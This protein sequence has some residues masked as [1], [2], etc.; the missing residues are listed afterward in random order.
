MSIPAA[1]LGAR[2][3]VL[4]PLVR[5][6]FRLG[7][8]PRPQSVHEDP[9]A[10]ALA[11]RV[12][13]TADLDA[14]AAWCHRLGAWLSWHRRSSPVS[15]TAE[16]ICDLRPC[17]DVPAASRRQPGRAQALDL[18]PAQGGFVEMTFAEPGVT[19]SGG[20]HLYYWLLR[21]FESQVP[22]QWRGVSCRQVRLGPSSGAGSGACQADSTPC[23]QSPPPMLRTYVRNLSY[24]RSLDSEASFREHAGRHADL[25]QRRGTDFGCAL[26]HEAG[27]LDE[28]L[29]ELE[30]SGPSF[31]F[32]QG[33]GCRP[34]SSYSEGGRCRV[35]RIGP[36]TPSDSTGP[37]G[38]AEP[39]PG[40]QRRRG[41]VEPP[42]AGSFASWDSVETARE[43]AEHT[44]LDGLQGDEETP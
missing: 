18:Q 32:C 42:P 19:R 20:V 11:S 44:P 23:R 29:Q 25:A 40:V 14:W 6:E 35:R 31:R 24:A 26:A 41:S 8:P 5:R 4:Q 27:R 15:R 7:N 28:R 1:Q 13:H 9:V 17:T 33:T 22:D 3:G 10:V 36:G 38:L 39:R 16:P 12:V 43:V 37:V 21:A 30:K 2:S 34:S